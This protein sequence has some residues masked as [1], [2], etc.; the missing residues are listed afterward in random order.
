MT[1]VF[2][3]DVSYSGHSMFCWDIYLGKAR[4]N[5][6]LSL[7]PQWIEKVVLQVVRGKVFFLFCFVFLLLK[8]HF[9]PLK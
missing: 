2:T 6:H 7:G 9:Q 5:L 3:A 4:F 1:V 8:D